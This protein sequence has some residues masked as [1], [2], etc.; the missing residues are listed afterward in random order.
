M[1][2]EK[3]KR[4][5]EAFSNEYFPVKMYIGGDTLLELDRNTFSYL[6]QLESD[7]TVAAKM[8]AIPPPSPMTNEIEMFFGMRNHEN[9]SLRQT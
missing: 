5:T 2:S 1:T 6:Q 9:I 4:S 8:G 7:G 3:L